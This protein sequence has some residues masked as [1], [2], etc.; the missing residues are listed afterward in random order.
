[1]IAEVPKPAELE[2]KADAPQP[3]APAPP[4]VEKTETS[5]PGLPPAAD[6]PLPRPPEEK[7]PLSAPGRSEEDLARPAGLPIL[8]LRAISH[9]PR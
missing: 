1:M 3:P 6:L 7:R 2:P 8:G 4:A 9:S 5:V